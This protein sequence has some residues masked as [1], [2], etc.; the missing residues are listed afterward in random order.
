MTLTESREE[1]DLN[2]SYPDEPA[3]DVVSQSTAGPFAKAVDATDRED[4]RYAV[5]RA[6]STLRVAVRQVGS[7]STQSVRQSSYREGSSASRLRR[8]T[9]EHA[10]IDAPADI[11]DDDERAVRAFI[12]A[13]PVDPPDE[14]ADPPQRRRRLR[15]V[16]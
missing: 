13:L 2:L 5:K 7:R 3:E 11:T 8:R 4:V 9:P 10:P 16:Q 14:D 6:Q 15:R 1:S 12:D